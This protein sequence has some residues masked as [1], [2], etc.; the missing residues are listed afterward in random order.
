MVDAIVKQV[1]FLN[2]DC[3]GEVDQIKK[4]SHHFSK[5]VKKTISMV[6]YQI[7][8]IMEKL[9]NKV[10]KY[11]FSIMEHYEINE[12][13]DDSNSKVKAEDKEETKMFYCESMLE[14]DAARVKKRRPWRGVGKSLVHNK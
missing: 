12:D 9:K 1:N 8:K 6:S 3:F 10:K 5:K 7:E 2:K 13:A 4:Y 11:D 14:D